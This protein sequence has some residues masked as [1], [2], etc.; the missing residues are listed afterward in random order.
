VFGGHFCFS[1][2]DSD[3]LK[4]REPDHFVVARGGKALWTGR[5]FLEEH[6]RGKHDA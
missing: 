4:K 6:N 3:F 1:T 2:R 5:E